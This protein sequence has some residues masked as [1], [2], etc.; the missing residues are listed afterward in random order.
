VR[1]F[2]A[3]EAQVDDIDLRLIQELQ[4][5]G[6]ETNADL[7]R[8]LN[9]SEGAIRKRINHL[10]NR[11]TMKILAVPNMRALGYSFTCIVG[12]EVRL[13]DLKSVTDTLAKNE[14]VCY[15]AWVT[16]RF[17]LMAVVVARSPEDYSQFLE[18]DVSAIPS[19]LRTETF[20]NLDIFKGE[21]GSLDY[22][23]L[24]DKSNL[25]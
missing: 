2:D 21:V 8:R 12:F 24:I 5:N 15:L 18:R 7:G 16:G 25:S 1:F 11:G 4:K 19:I 23:Q 10:L 22:S 20:V 13:P 17:S 9:L 6:R 3:G 14:H